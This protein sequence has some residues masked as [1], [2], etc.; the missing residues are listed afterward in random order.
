MGQTREQKVLKQLSGIPT[1]QK[2]TPI[3][4]G[5]FLPNHSGISSHPEFKKAL[6]AVGGSQTPWTSDIDGDNYDLK[7]VG[8]VNAV[9]VLSSEYIANNSFDTDTLFTT[10]NGTITWAAGSYT[11]L[12]SA[13][14]HQD[15][16]DMLITPSAGVRRYKYEFH[17]SAYSGTTPVFYPLYPNN[18]A[19]IITGTGTYSGEADAELTDPFKFGGGGSGDSSITVDYI[20]IKEITKGDITAEHKMYADNFVSK[21]GA[22]T[23]FVKGDGTLDASTYLTDLST[24]TTDD[25]TEGS[26]NKYFNGKTTDDLSEG[27]TNIYFNNG[28]LDTISDGSTYTKQMIAD[29]ATAYS[30]GDWSGQGFYTTKSTGSAVDSIDFVNQTYTTITVVTDVS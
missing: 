4:D 24:F 6:S 10:E 26:T 14:K 30:W 17:V 21:G 5:M 29:G 8:N 23:D 12:A 3:A 25:L 20:S 28:T 18:P 2:F 27:S 7:D 19:I 15:F 9:Q 16:S 11:F 22:S 1:T 13:I